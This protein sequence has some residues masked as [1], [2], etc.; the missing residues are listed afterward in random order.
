MSVPLFDLRDQ[1]QQLQPELEAA[2]RRVVFSGRFIQGPE[3]AAFES[4][5][6]GY[7][8]VRHAVGVASGT[9]AIWL[10]LRALGIGPGD[11]VVTASFTFFATISAILNTGAEPLLVDIRPDTFNIDVDQVG[12]V[13]DDQKVKAIVP[14]HL[15]GQAADMSPLLEL[16]QSHN[17]PVVEDAAQ[18]MGARYS[19][20]SLGTLGALGCFSFFPTKNL[21]AFG[22]GGLVVT[23]DDDLADRVRLL[24]GHGSRPRYY[25]QIVGTNSRLDELQAAFLRVKLPHL[26]DWVEARRQHAAAYDSGLADL[27]DVVTPV[28]IP[29][30]HHAY[31]QYTLRAGPRRDALRSFLEQ[32]RIGSSVYYPVPAHRQEA[33]ADAAYLPAD[34]DASE[35]ASQEV[36]SLPIFPEMTAEQRQHVIDA[37]VEFCPA[38]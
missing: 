18:G 17:I 2:F 23:D 12:K 4:E 9:D 26:A 33:V 16:A 34:L 14:V 35:N 25:H 30:A 21:G 1:N 36:L 19:G 8:G 13:L 37:V 10:A 24:K 22:D 29:Q 7:L 28:S 5:I 27:V 31:H 38:G 6:A 20:R 11:R 15:F 3:V 32:R